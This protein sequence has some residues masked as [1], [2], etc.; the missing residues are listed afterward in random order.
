[1]ERWKSCFSKKRYPTPWNRIY[2]TPM[3]IFHYLTMQEKKGCF[4]VDFSDS[5][6]VFPRIF[7]S[8]HP[9]C[10]KPSSEAYLLRTICLWL[11]CSDFLRI[12]NLQGTYISCV[13]KLC[14]E[15]IFMAY[16]LPQLTSKYPRYLTNLFQRL[17][18]VGNTSDTVECIGWDYDWDHPSMSLMRRFTS[19]PSVL[20]PMHT[21][22]EAYLLGECVLSS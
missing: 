11:P 15:K 10:R 5:H 1:M 7:V 2:L 9:C 17:C 20:S 12:S 22:N 4:W 13:L 19:L 6:D 18:V 8:Y 21:L 3:L 14:S 16:P